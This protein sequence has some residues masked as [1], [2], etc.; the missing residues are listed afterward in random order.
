M[1]LSRW[2]WTR[3]APRPLLVT[4][5]GGRVVRLMTERLIRERGW[6]LATSP[7]DAD[8]LVVCGTA[9]AT[10]ADAVERVWSQSR[11]TRAG[12]DRMAAVTTWAAVTTYT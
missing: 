12:T 9:G 6:E 3:A 2:L 4:V 10:L 7:A 5:P 11:H 8:L 1:D